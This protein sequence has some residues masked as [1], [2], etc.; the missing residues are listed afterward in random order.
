MKTE[1]P[2]AESRSYNIAYNTL[3]RYTVSTAMWGTS[4]A[5]TGGIHPTYETF[6]WDWDSEKKERGKQRKAYYHSNREQAIEFHF[7][8]CVKL[9]IFE[10][11]LEYGDR[12]RI[13]FQ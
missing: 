8:F 6:I 7:K 3:R 5:S 10:L 9:T 1:M 4:I 11:R 2:N 13:Y 12:D